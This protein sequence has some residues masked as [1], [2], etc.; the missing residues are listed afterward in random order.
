MRGW[1]I[2]KLQNSRVHMTIKEVKW[3]LESG[4]APRQ[5]KLLA[6]ASV[7]GNDFFTECDIP[8]RV[9]H[10]PLDYSRSDLIKFYEDLEDIKLGITRQ[11]EAT[12]KMVPQIM[13][14]EFPKFA[15][16]HVKDTRRALEIWMATIGAGITVDRRDDVRDI[17]KLLEQS[18]PYLDTAM[19]EILA[20]ENK[21]S[22][23]IG[24]SVSVFSLLARQDWKNYCD[25]FPSQFS[26]DLKY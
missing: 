10:R 6:L 1:V 22:D 23:I 11:L 13:G 16:D 15:E 3:D 5:A 12:K 4:G 9:A 19:D 26:H 18:K 8:H 14:I 7:L 2:K 21:T 17:W 24:E 25:F 20:D